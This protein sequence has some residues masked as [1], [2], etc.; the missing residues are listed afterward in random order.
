M[1]NILEYS[2]AKGIPHSAVKELKNS[3]VGKSPRVAGKMHTTK[4]K[5]NILFGKIVGYFLLYDLGT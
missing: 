5:E 3:I 1:Q 4:E 2:P